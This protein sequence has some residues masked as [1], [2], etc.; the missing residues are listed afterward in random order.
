MPLVPGPF[1][2][3]DTS[4]LN[5]APVNYNF[6][7]EATS[8]LSGLDAVEATIDTEMATLVIFAGGSDDPIGGAI[9]LAIQNFAGLDPDVAITGL[10]GMAD[11]SANFDTALTAGIAK[12]PAAAFV[13]TNAVFVPPAPPNLNAPIVDGS[14]YSAIT[15]LQAGIALSDPGTGKYVTLLNITRPGA[16]SFMVGDDIEIRVQGMAG[17]DVGYSATQNGVF[18]ANVDFATLP[19]SGIYVWK[20]QLDPTQVGVW[21]ETWYVGGQQL[22][23]LN[24]VVTKAS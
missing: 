21:A 14:D 10:T 15:S 3:Q 12:A 8:D 9:D 5:W 1:S 18:V 22:G 17:D 24:F 23:A 13:P 7:A 16:S 6:T 11:A 4:V 20:G 19:S 2:L